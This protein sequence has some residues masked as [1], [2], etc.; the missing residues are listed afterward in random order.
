MH[1][2]PLEVLLILHSQTKSHPV[3]T[4]VLLTTTDA[5]IYETLNKRETEY[6]FGTDM[7]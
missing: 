7:F 2:N 5:V 6:Q 1:T 4:G 3:P